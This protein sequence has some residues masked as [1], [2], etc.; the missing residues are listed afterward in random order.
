MRVKA[1]LLFSLAFAGS[2]FCDSFQTTFLAAGVETPLGIT[3][4]YETFDGIAPG[5]NNLPFTTTY[6]NSGFTG[7]YSGAIDWYA[8]DVFG[9]ASGKAT[10]PET[11]SGYTVTINPSVNYFGLWFSALDAG[12]QLSFYRDNTLLYT[13]TPADFIRLVGNCPGSGFC[14]NPNANFQGGDNGQQYAYL[15]FY[16]SNGT[17]N[18]IVFSETGGGGFESDNHAVGL[19]ASAPGGT[20]VTTP[21][22]ATTA[23]LGMVLAAGGLIYRKK[24]A[25]V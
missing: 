5:A 4:H 21:E 2:A 9:G 10:Y 1:F 23:A 6:N 15:N 19:L 14:G 18:K 20:P 17:F 8:A 3:S 24:R 11:F 13:F 16:D 12:N 25:A 7:T 22:P